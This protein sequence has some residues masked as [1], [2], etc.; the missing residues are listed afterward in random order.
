MINQYLPIF[1][2]VSLAVKVSSDCQDLTLDD[3]R[4][5]T[6]KPPFQSVKLEEEET[7]QKYCSD[8]FPDLCTFFIYD[9][10]QN[11]C[12]LYSYDPEEYVE[13]CNIIG[14]TP[15]PSL[16]ECKNLDDECLVRIHKYEIFKRPYLEINYFYFLI[17]NR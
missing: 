12:N 4:G 11:G 1:A 9:R 8:I 6:N 15:L 17:L 2:I 5:K 3:C 14:G 13:S 10:Q 7:C 16:S